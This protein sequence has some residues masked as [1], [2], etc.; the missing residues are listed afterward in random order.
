MSVD[1]E[2][3]ED[4]YVKPE[5]TSAKEAPEV[6][7]D[8]DLDP[9]WGHGKPWEKSQEEK[10]VR[11]YKDGFTEEDLGKVFGRTPRSV[12]SK[13]IRIGA[14]KA[15]PKPK[16]PEAKRSR[17]NELKWTPEQDEKIKALV[18][19]MTLDEIEAETGWSRDRVYRRMRR[20]GIK[21]KWRTVDGSKKRHEHWTEEEANRALELAKKW[22]L[23]KVAKIIGRS[24]LSVE[25]K[26]QRDFGG[27]LRH[28]VS[29]N[30]IAEEIGVCHR[31]VTEIRDRLGMKFRVM[32]SRSDMNH[33]GPTPKQIVMICDE[34]LKSNNVSAPINRVKR[35]RE[36]Y[37]GMS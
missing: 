24:V 1:W 23:E 19:T 31:T 11:L 34:V 12:E 26:I 27:A 22:P 17:Y 13:L 32:R 3:P 18:E 8:T 7:L 2:W 5:G 33:F 10:L 35:V 20:L 25:S 36:K 29:I 30:E 9:L 15:K 6:S 16:K 4:W 28:R 21:L 37:A 14:K